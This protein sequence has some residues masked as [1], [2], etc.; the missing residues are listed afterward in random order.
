MEWCKKLPRTADPDFIAFIDTPSPLTRKLREKWL[1]QLAYNKDWATYDRYYSD[2]TDTNLQC[3]ALTAMY[4]EGKIQQTKDRIAS[5]WLNGNSQPKACDA[6]FNTLL[7]QHEISDEL[8]HKRIILALENNNTSLARYLLKHYQPARTQDADLLASIRQTPLL[9]T[10]LKP[11]EFHDA[12]YLYG[13]KLIASRNLDKAIELFETTTLLNETQKQQFIADV[14]LQKA[15]HNQPDTKQWFNRVHAA[16]RN[17]TLIEWQ[18]KYSLLHHQWAEIITLVDQSNTPNE[19]GFQYWKARALQ[20]LGQPEAAKI[21]YQ[22][23][24]QKRNY[25]GFLASA[26]LKK[27]PNFENELVTTNSQRLLPYQ[28]ITEQIRLLYTTHQTLDASRLL[29]DFMLELPKQDKSALTYWLANQL[30]WYGKSIYLSSAPDLNNQLETRFP[31]AHWNAVKESANSYQIPGELIYAVIRQES[32]F[33]HDIVSSAGANG[34][35][36]IMPATAKATAKQAHIQYSDKKQLF[37]PQKNIHIGTAYLKLLAKQYHQHPVLMMSAYN[38]GPRQTNYWLK[39]HSP[40]DIDIWIE[41]LPWRE[42]R[43]YLKNILSFYA[44]YQFRT[45]KTPDLSA[46]MRRFS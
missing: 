39:N 21:V 32:M 30:H 9:I 17:E 26:R 10:T 25:Y 42:T 11:G 45:H 28:P 12:F 8:L 13:L 15:I 7:S 5:L 16:F 34:L 6:L 38:A 46:F 1:Y 40:T 29:N 3:H 14:A 35:M 37:S 36:Q 24:A 19:P 20:A 33:N 22:Q 2:S 27:H 18:I 43:N 23:V 31:L 4:H 44:V 41:T